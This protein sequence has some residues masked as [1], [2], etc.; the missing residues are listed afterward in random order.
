MLVTTPEA[1]IP[2]GTVVV[3]GQILEVRQHP[4]FVRYFFDLFRRVGGTDALSNGDLESL[5]MALDDAAGRLDVLAA[6]M[7][8]IQAAIDRVQAGE[9]VIQPLAALDPISAEVTWQI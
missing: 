5:V 3:Q 7:A 4:E 8:A 6:G 2:I 9:V 1:N